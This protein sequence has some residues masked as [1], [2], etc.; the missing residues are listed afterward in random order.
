M[1]DHM[2]FAVTI[3]V[4]KANLSHLIPFELVVVSAAIA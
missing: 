4:A 3:G 1:E 2:L